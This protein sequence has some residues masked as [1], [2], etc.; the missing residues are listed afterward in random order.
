[1]PPKGAARAGP[2]G[3]AVMTISKG[4]GMPK[5]CKGYS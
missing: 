5:P 3:G 1:M 2:V 4:G